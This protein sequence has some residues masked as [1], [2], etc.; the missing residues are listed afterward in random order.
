MGAE[1]LTNLHLSL[2]LKSRRVRNGLEGRTIAGNH[3]RQCLGGQCRNNRPQGSVR[4]E[5]QL[6]GIFTTTTTA[7]CCTDMS[8]RSQHPPNTDKHGQT[9]RSGRVTA[10]D[11]K[12]IR[13]ETV[14]SIPCAA[15]PAEGPTRTDREAGERRAQGDGGRGRCSQPK[16]ILHAK[17]ARRRRECTE[18]ML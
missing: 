4:V 3:R 5:E 1:G 12:G 7:A 8:G 15:L 10:R 6:R 14:L 16:I 17:R 2:F 18:P 13:F 9:K 11:C